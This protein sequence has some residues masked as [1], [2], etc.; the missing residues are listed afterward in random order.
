MLSSMCSPRLQANIASSRAAVATQP[1]ERLASTAGIAL[2]VCIAFVLLSGCESFRRIPSQDIEA[3]RES[4]ASKKE[5]SLAGW[6]TVMVG[7]RPLLKT[8]PQ[9]TAVVLTNS[10]SFS[11]EAGSPESVAMV[12]K[13][14]E[15]TEVG[16]AAVVAK[17]GYFLT[18]GHVVRDASSL[19]LIVL[20]PQENGSPQVRRAPARVVWAPPNP[21]LEADLAVV[22]ADVGPLEPFR[23]AAE[24]P[25]TDD[26]IISAAWQRNTPGSEAVVPSF[27]GGR[28]LHAVTYETLGSSPPYTAVRHDTP[29]AWGDSGGAVVDRSGDLIGV[30]SIISFPISNWPAFVSLLGLAIRIDPQQLTATAIMPDPVW[31]RE[32]IEQDRAMSNSQPRT[33]PEQP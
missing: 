4:V 31:L 27:S 10:T 21:E 9:R 16:S 20:I 18:A 30:N 8:L 6:D 32:V 28:V 29:I 5:E 11:A 26:Q 22:Y 14:S 25:L 13:I 1:S 33:D 17:D 19:T 23:L 2:A 24:A 7:D 12:I 3:V 15:P